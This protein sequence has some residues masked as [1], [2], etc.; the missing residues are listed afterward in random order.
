MKLRPSSANPTKT[1]QYTNHINAS[2]SIKRDL[3][4]IQSSQETGKFLDSQIFKLTEASFFDHKSLAST[5]ITQELKVLKTHTNKTQLCKTTNNWKIEKLALELEQTKSAENYSKRIPLLKLRIEEL[6]KEILAAKMNQEIRLEDR[7]VY[8]HI[9]KRMVDTKIHLELKAHHLREQMN[10][11]TGILITEKTKYWKHK[12]SRCKSARACRNF[13]KTSE[14]FRKSK[15]ILAKRF[16]NEKKASEEMDRLRF[17]HERRHV[18]IC[19]QVDNEETIR[20]FKGIREQVMLSKFWYSFLSNKLK[21]NIV[22]FGAIDLAFRKI[23]SITGLTDITEVV[24]KFLTKENLYNELMTMVNQ[25]KATRENMLK[26]NRE[27][28]N[29]IEEFNISEKHLSIGQNLRELLEVIQSNRARNGYEKERLEKIQ[30]LRIKLESWIRKIILKFKG[31]YEGLKNFSLVELMMVLKSSVFEELGLM[32]I[33]PNS[34]VLK[35]ITKKI[36]VD[37]SK[38]S[39]SPMACKLIQKEKLKNEELLLS[40]LNYSDEV[41][42]YKKKIFFTPLLDKALRKTK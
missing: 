21:D 16:E 2:T 11:K 36:V 30:A 12:E 5:Q 32:N 8:F 31:T 4:L 3:K 34:K 38:L 29:K 7:E 41:S 6:K 33:P 24:E 25:N 9:E 20:K 19:E 22:K 39:S 1:R 26:K 15:I 23:R 42:D 10:I 13:D 37:A 17:E 35:E 28:E 40:Q 27:L 14:F 18:E